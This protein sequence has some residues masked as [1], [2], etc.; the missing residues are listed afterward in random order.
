MLRHEKSSGPAPIAFPHRIRA[1][2][3]SGMEQ[4]TLNIHVESENEPVLVLDSQLREELIAL[5]KAVVVA[6]YEA[7]TGGNDDGLS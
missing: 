3:G 5:M 4:L 7:G 6:V 2:R 1:K